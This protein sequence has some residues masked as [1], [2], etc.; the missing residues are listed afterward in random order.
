MEIGLVRRRKRGRE[1]DD[2]S[3]GPEVSESFGED[4]VCQWP[5]DSGGGQNC[6]FSSRKVCAVFLAIGFQLSFQKVGVKQRKPVGLRLA[7]RPK[8]SSSDQGQWDDMVHGYGQRFHRAT[9]IYSQ[10]KLICR[11]DLMG[12]E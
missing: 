1:S 5:W 7:S 4:H 12:E 6:F 11:K 3:K 10:T 9:Y 2:E 8:Y